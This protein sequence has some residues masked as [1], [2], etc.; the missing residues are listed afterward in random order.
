LNLRTFSLH[1]FAH[2]LS[3]SIHSLHSLHSTHSPTHSLSA[4][5]LSPLTHSLT[6]LSPLNPWG[7]RVRQVSL[8]QYPGGLSL[9][10]KSTNKIYRKFVS[11][12]HL[13][14][15]S[16]SIGSGAKNFCGIEKFAVARTLKKLKYQ[17][18]SWGL[19][20]FCKLIYLSE[21]YRITKNIWFLKKIDISEIKTLYRYST[22]T[23][24]ILKH[25]RWAGHEP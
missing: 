4:H 6:L 8:N 12:L 2:S 17:I 11:F 3:H 24:T 1:S 16:V 9:K 23:P 15:S 25:Y 5:S 10:T 22:S 13:S 21:I 18:T 7:L 20:L 19:F 14:A